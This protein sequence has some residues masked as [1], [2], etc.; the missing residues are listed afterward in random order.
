MKLIMILTLIAST[1]FSFECE[2]DIINLSKDVF[3]SYYKK[4]KYVVSVQ[5]LQ[6]CIKKNSPLTKDAKV[7]ISSLINSSFADVH[8]EAEKYHKL[9]SGEMRAS[10]M[11]RDAYMQDALD[12]SKEITKEMIAQIAQMHATSK[13]SVKVTSTDRE[14]GKK[15][16]KTISRGPAISNSKS[17]QTKSK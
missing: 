16:Y 5:E 10:E 14:T 9:A 8:S 6:S 17:T 15:V 13:K 2:K 12:S 1:A 11:E 3:K 7:K 4:A